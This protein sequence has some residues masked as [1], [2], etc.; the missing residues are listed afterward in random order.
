LRDEGFAMA[1]EHTTELSV[2]EKIE[3][4][5]PRLQAIIEEFREAAPRERLDYL[6]EFALD[7]PDLPA[8]LQGHRETMEQVHECQTPVFLHTELN[9]GQVEFFLDIPKES[10]TVRGYAGILVSGFEGASP[11]QVLDT[12]DD[13][14]HLLGLQEVITPQRLR[15]LH[16]LFAYM[17]R[18]V[19][20]VMND[21]KLI[22]RPDRS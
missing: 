14:Y 1:I 5:P 15:G 17:K 9:N 16:A 3:R 7:L 18:Q 12:P 11:Q 8:R 6:L 2:E 22:L 20:Q 13:V 4:C 19:I 21:E 10:P